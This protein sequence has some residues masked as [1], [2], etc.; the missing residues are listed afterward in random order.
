MLI[1]WDL[2][3]TF[4][5]NIWSNKEYDGTLIVFNETPIT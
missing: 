3:D 4:E 2:D 1:L 5:K